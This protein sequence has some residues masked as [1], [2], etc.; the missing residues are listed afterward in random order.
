MQCSPWNRQ[1]RMRGLDSNNVSNVKTGLV[2]GS[3]GPSTANLLAAFD[4]TRQKG[5]KRVGPYMVPRCMSSTVSACIATFLKFAGSITR[6]HQHVLHLHIVLPL[7]LTLFAVAARILYLLA[8]VRNCIGPCLFYLML[9][10]PCH[11]NITILQ[12]WH[13]ALMIP[14]ETDLLLLAAVAW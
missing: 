6:F 1:L 5:P 7:V 4:I 10:A 14:L 12:N 8:E 13:H 2:A 3:G 9:W 11:Q